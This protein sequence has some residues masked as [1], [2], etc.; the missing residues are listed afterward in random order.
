LSDVISDTDLRYRVSNYAVGISRL[1]PIG[2]GETQM[3]SFIVAKR[4]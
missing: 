2:T 4:A 3:A 1:E